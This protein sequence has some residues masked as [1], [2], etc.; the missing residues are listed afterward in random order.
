MTVGAGAPEIRIPI[1]AGIDFGYC[2]DGRPN[3]DVSVLSYMPSL[4]GAIQLE[5]SFDLALEKAGRLPIT[6]VLVGVACPKPN[7]IGCGRIGIAVWP[8][9]AVDQLDAHIGPYT[10]TL[11][12]QGDGSYQ[13]FVQADLKRA[14]FYIRPDVTGYWAGNPAAPFSLRLTG[15]TRASE[16]RT[17]DTTTTGFIAAGWG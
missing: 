12:P 17:F 13:G 4:Q 1:P 14:P 9:R 7:R 5:E 10:T 16:T 3:S 11:K 6:R 8:Q 2:S 15:R